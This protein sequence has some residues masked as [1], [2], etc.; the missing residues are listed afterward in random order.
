MDLKAPQK[1]VLNSKFPGEAGVEVDGEGG[2]GWNCG[3]R[4]HETLEKSAG[5]R[6]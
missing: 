2:V 5:S 4:F 3:S 1:V 6:V